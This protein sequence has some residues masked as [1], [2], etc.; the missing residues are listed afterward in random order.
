[1][2]FYSLFYC[3]FVQ[4]KALFVEFLIS[5]VFLGSPNILVPYFWY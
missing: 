4:Y 5:A 3:L 1:L 2:D